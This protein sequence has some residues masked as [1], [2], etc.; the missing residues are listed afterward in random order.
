MVALWVLSSS[1]VHCATVDSCGRSARMAMQETVSAAV[2][3]SFLKADSMQA[4]TAH[5]T[6]AWESIARLS[7]RD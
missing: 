3:V 5:S 2:V 1:S 7:M 4:S 6:A